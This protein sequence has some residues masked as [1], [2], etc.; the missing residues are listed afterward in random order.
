MTKEQRGKLLTALN[1]ARVIDWTRSTDCYDTFEG[2]L[3][4]RYK[5]K[6]VRISFTELSSDGNM[7]HFNICMTY[8]NEGGS[9]YTFAFDEITSFI[10][11]VLIKMAELSLNVNKGR[12]DTLSDVLKDVT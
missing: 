8:P 9:G 7:E 11:S 4:L 5:D 2:G 1:Q 6:E 12:A 10:D 3:P